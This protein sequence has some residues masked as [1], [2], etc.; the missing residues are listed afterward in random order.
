MSRASSTRWRP[1]YPTAR[2]FIRTAGVAG[3][4]RARR[5]L[6]NVADASVAFLRPLE[7]LPVDTTTFNDGKRIAQAYAMG[8]RDAAAGFKPCQPGDSID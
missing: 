1:A 4:P 3:D 7:K 8:M 2:R 6:R 5:I